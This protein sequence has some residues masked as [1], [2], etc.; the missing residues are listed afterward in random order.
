MEQTKIRIDAEKAGIKIAMLRVQDLETNL[1]LL[2]KI[3]VNLKDVT[4]AEQAAARMLYG[5]FQH[6]PTDEEIAGL[7]QFGFNV[8]NLDAIKAIWFLIEKKAELLPRVKK[9]VVITGGTATASTGEKITAMGSELLDILKG[10]AMTVKEIVAG[11]KQR[12]RGTNEGSVNRIVTE[13][14][15]AGRVRKDSTQKPMRVV[16][17]G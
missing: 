5:L 11:Y 13:M 17:V 6:R 12:G 8:P 7:Q 14:E 4:N 10:G 9:T 16:L 3:S 2:R 1:E 15:A